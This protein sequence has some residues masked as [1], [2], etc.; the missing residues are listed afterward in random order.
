MGLAH[1]AGAEQQQV[2]GPIQPA[3][4]MGQLLDL[5][6]IE[7]GDGAPVNVRQRLRNRQLGL[8]QQP[9]Q[10]RLVPLLVFLLRQYIEVAAGIPALG[11]G[12]LFGR[13]P[14][15]ADLGKF[16]LFQ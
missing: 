6:A 9:P 15:A 14:L 7:V 13:L 8:M 11:S 1:A 5:V 12:L 3:G 2:L 16:Q 10:P 4:V